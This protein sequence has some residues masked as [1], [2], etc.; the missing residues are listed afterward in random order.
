[1][2]GLPISN[3]RLR[4]KIKFSN[5]IKSCNRK[6]PVT[7]RSMG[8][9]R[10]D[11]GYGLRMLLKQPGFTLI[12]VLTLGLGIGANLTIFSF[13]DTFFLRPIPAPDPERLVNVEAT[14]NGR[15]F[16]YYAY[17]TYLPYRDHCTAFESLA[18]HYSTAPLNITT[19]ADSRVANGAVVSAN[20][21][22]MLG[23]QPRLGRFF[24]RE[25]DA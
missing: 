20:Y 24:L 2:M 23:I 1:M 6:S 25:E 9:L 15:W 17:P 8:T 13:V 18:A 5:S 16:G 21:F 14:R 7:G 12:A 11:I 10:R 19:D 4:I 3:S 22:S